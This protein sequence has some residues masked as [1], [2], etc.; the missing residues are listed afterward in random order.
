MGDKTYRFV[1]V[2][3]NVGRE[4]MIRFEGTLVEYDRLVHGVP[5]TRHAN[6]CDTHGYGR[7]RLR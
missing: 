5:D 6:H 3:D 7:Q 1:T 4:L 2:I